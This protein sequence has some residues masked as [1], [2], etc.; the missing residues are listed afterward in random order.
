MAGVGGD[1]GGGVTGFAVAGLP[2]DLAGGGVETGGGL[3]FAADIEV[4]AVGDDRWAGGVAINGAFA[5]EVIDEVGFPKQGAGVEG[6]AVQIAFA[7]EVIDFFAGDG[8]GG[9][10]AVGDDG[11][12]VALGGD[13]ELMTPEDLAGGE[14]ETEDG[15]VVLAVVAGG[16]D[17]VT[18]DGEAGEAEADLLAP[19]DRGAVGGPVGEEAGLGGGAVATGALVAGPVAFGGG[20]AGGEARCGAAGEGGF[21]G[22]FGGFEGG[23]VGGGEGDDF[24]W[25]FLAFA[26]FTAEGDEFARATG[27]ESVEEAGVDEFGDGHP[28][29]ATEFE[30]VTRDA[31]GEEAAFVGDCRE[32]EAAEFVS[33][34]GWA[35]GPGAGGG[36]ENIDAGDGLFGGVHAADGVEFLADGVDGEG[37]ALEGLGMALPLGVGFGEVEGEVGVVP[38][39]LEGGD[40]AAA[41]G[42]AADDVEGFAD[43]DAVVGGAALF[44]L[45]EVLPGGGGEVEGGGGFGG[46]EVLFFALRVL[47]GHAADA[48]DAI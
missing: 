42:P 35:S 31:G 41:E 44:E 23:G 47:R 33:G 30:E 40:F 36:V 14:A 28:L 22:G 9:G 39:G 10:G 26:A 21:G 18:S 43:D 27:E 12:L 4:E 20:E 37:A 1:E 34:Q 6:E 45:G 11:H 15:F 8:G 48:D 17:A 13:V 32:T 46:P 16:D 2:E 38:V 5:A 24:G 29:A 25:G 3:A 19:G 7:G